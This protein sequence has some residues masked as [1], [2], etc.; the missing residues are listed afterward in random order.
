MGKTIVLAL[1]IGQKWLSASLSKLV[2]NYAALLPTQGLL[3]TAMEYLKLQGSEESSHELSLLQNHIAPSAEGGNAKHDIL[4]RTKIA[5]YTRLYLF[6]WQYLQV[7]K[8]VQLVVILQLIRYILK[9]L[10]SMHGNR[11]IAFFYIKRVQFI[12]FN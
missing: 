3:S 1:A 12:S 11:Q 7:I 4:F 10:V 6:Y 2:G 8:L 5:Y 9:F